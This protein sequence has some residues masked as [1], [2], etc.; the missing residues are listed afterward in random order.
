MKLEK[1]K[2]SKAKEIDIIDCVKDLLR[3][4]T[5]LFEFPEGLDGWLFRAS[6]SFIKPLLPI[7]YDIYVIKG[8]HPKEDTWD[9]MQDLEGHTVGLFYVRKSIFTPFKEFGIF[10]KKK[11]RNCGLGN[12]AMR[13]I[14]LEYS[15]IILKVRQDNPA[16]IHLYKK[17]GFVEVERNINMVYKGYKR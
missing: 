10:I 13:F 6:T 15:N 14:T 5:P 16:G 7:Q 4:Y 12:I 8:L 3:N 17:H 9:I 1:T 2:I 11:Y